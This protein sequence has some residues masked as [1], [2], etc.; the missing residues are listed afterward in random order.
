MG[1]GWEPNDTKTVFD[2]NK[3]GGERILREREREREWKDRDRNI[4]LQ[5]YLKTNYS[6]SSDISWLSIQGG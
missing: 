5:S 2:V 4:F 6:V 1:K 3:L